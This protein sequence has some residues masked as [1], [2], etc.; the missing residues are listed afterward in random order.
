MAITMPEMMLLQKS[1]PPPH[2]PPPAVG[3][4]QNQGVMRTHSP[5]SAASQPAQL[6]APVLLVLVPDSVSVE[7]TQWFCTPISEY[8]TLEPTRGGPPDRKRT[9]PCFEGIE[10][11]LDPVYAE[12]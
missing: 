2:N 7:L 6:A 10:D 5:I 3:A 8:L 1:Q 4:P 11:R 9:S 12:R